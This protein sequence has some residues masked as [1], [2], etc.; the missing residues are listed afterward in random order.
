M[1]AMISKI[2]ANPNYISSL[3]GPLALA[4][5][6]ESNRDIFNLIDYSNESQIRLIIDSLIFPSFNRLTDSTKSE[7]NRALGYFLHHSNVASDVIT[8]KLLLCE[9]PPSF[10]REFMEALWDFL[11]P[12]ESAKKVA[13]SIVGVKNR[14]LVVGEYS[15]SR[16]A[17]FSLDELVEKLRKRLPV[18]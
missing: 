6:K 5:A 10:H 11:F 1:S 17:D 16:K 14:P 8:E 12:G 9:I 4:A 7:I 13:E 15:F 18:D 3:L 2:K